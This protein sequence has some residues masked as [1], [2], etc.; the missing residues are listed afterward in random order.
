MTE[1]EE[2]NSTLVVGYDGSNA[3]QKALDYAASRVNGGKLFVVTAVV[4]PPEWMGAPHW[5]EIVD[6]EHTRGEHLLAD[7]VE[8]LPD[9][10]DYATELLEGPAA[11]AIVK[12]ADTR[13]ADAIF[14]GSRGPAPRGARGGRGLRG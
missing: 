7:A 2:M 8:R 3:A 14:V 12:V 13:D 6:E 5:Q 1:G 11:D 10:I 9:G 4:P